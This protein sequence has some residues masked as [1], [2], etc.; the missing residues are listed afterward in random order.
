MNQVALGTSAAI[1]ALP[2]VE[3]CPNPTNGQVIFRAATTVT[4]L[5]LFDGLGRVL[6]S[7]YPNSSTGEID[8][9][10]SEAG[11]YF[12]R[13]RF[14]NGSTWTERVIRE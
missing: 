5:T 13:M 3:L 4:H 1:P 2:T 14:A 8:L 10:E 11:V 6:F 12:V 9:S 7:A